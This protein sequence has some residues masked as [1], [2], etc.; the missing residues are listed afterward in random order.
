MKKP[1]AWVGSAPGGNY[2]AKVQAFASKMGVGVHEI[3]VTHDDWCA[4]LRR[5][6]PCNCDPDVSL[7]RT[8]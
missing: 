4:L 6:M 2:T 8:K 1:I 5:G 3:D 7:R